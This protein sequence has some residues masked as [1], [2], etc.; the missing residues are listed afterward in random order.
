MRCAFGFVGSILAALSL[1]VATGCVTVGAYVIPQKCYLVTVDSLE[2]IIVTGYRARVVNRTD[3]CVY[4]W[5]TPDMGYYSQEMDVFCGRTVVVT[6][7]DCP[8]ER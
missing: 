6:A 4:V 1:I 5:R 3:P 8:V 7:Q 2:P